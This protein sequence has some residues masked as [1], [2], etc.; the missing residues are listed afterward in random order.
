MGSTKSNTR[1]CGVES[2]E[3]R[4]LMSAAPH[5]LAFVDGRG[6]LYVNGTGGAD[7]IT[8]VEENGAVRL[9]MNASGKVTQRT[10]E[11]VRNVWIA[12]GRGDDAVSCDV[13]TASAVVDGG[14]NNDLI[15][16]CDR[17]EPESPDVHKRWL[18]KHS[19]WFRGSYVDGG[20]GDD[21]ILVEDGYRTFVNARHGN[22]SIIAFSDEPIRV[23]NNG[24]WSLNGNGN[25]NG[26]TDDA[27]N[28]GV[29][30]T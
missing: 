21:Q 2:L 4:R 14:S 11:G 26:A 16:L 23:Y 20:A 24:R 25:G 10:F 29:L 8:L 3:G 22:D 27:Q 30:S 6:G 1:F 19:D 12:A 18:G 9:E 5:G 13:S 15:Y 17:R 7:A 28:D